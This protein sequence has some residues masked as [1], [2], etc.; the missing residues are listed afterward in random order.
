M[1]LIEMILNILMGRK[2]QVIPKTMPS[3]IVDEVRN[4]LIPYTDKLWLSDGTFGLVNMQNLLEF[5]WS[6]T[7][8]RRSYITEKHDCDDF[9]YELMG[10][11][12]DWNPDNTF[13]IVWGTNRSGDGHAWNFFIDENKK[14]K[15]VEPQNDVIFDPSTEQIWM[16]IV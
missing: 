8:S 13:G 14:V 16:M 2:E 7:V 4:I 10:R 15:Y 3:I 1:N 9:S 12:S 5:L 6:D 11:V